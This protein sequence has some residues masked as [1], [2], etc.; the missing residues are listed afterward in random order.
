[1]TGM[2]GGLKPEKALDVSDLAHLR[3]QLRTPINHILGYGEMLEEEA[4][5]NSHEHYVADLQKIQEAARNL[6]SLIEAQFSD[7]ISTGSASGVFRRSSKKELSAPEKSSRKKESLSGRI[8][9]VDDIEENRDILARRL[10]RRGLEVAM[11]TNGRHALEVLAKEQF[12][13]VLL[14]VM[15][16]ELDGYSTL[17][18]MKQESHLKHIPVIMISSLDELESVTKCIEAGAEDYLPKPFN[19]ILLGARLSASLEKKALRD[20][21]QNYLKEIQTTQARLSRE[22]N[23]ASK[24]VRDLFPE[25]VVD[26]RGLSTSWHAVPCSELAGDAFGYH[27]I[28]SDHFAIYL[29][30][31]CGHGVRP[32]LLAASVLNVLRSGATGADM[33]NPSAVMSALNSLFPMERQNNLYFTIWY[34]VYSR[35]SGQLNYANAGHPDAILLKPSS[36]GQN[37]IIRMT[38]TGSV[39]GAFDDAEYDS[40]SI[41][42]EPGSTLIVFSDGC[43]EIEDQEGVMMNISDIETFFSRNDGGKTRPEDWYNEARSLNREASMND[44]FTMLRIDF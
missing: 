33:L 21:E 38:S 10:K 26:D 32:C 39:I 12:D 2:E 31:V 25:P 24:Y 13:A 16:P 1:M 8:L 11:A 41:S 36:D 34:G 28:D 5:A 30:D 9:V 43:F 7:E 20:A 22:L 17:L 23:D 15:M 4:S 18:Q 29:L 44:D 6:L 35:V 42:I 40:E 37:Q 27:W 3:H 19:P 14:D